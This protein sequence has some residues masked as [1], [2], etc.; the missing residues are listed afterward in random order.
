MKPSKVPCRNSRL[1]P[2][3]KIAPGTAITVTALI[4]EAM[5]DADT[6]HQGRFLPP[7][8]NPSTPLDLPLSR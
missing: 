4:C 1:P 7:R 2:W 6:A 8:K 5:I 3:A